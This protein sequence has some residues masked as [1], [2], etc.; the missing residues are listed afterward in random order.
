MAQSYPVRAATISALAE[1]AM[2][3]GGCS[4]RYQEMGFTGRV[5]SEQMS[6]DVFR[7]KSSGNAYTEA[8][9]VQDYV[10]LKAAERM[11]AARISR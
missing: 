4:T 6:A 9:T 2:L 3:L 5:A 1:A 7:I 11:R 10:L 8:T